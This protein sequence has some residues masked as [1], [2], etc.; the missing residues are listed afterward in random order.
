MKLFP[1]HF[2]GRDFRSSLRTWERFLKLLLPILTDFHAEQN[3]MVALGGGNGLDSCLEAVY[4]S[5]TTSGFGHK[6]LNDGGSLAECITAHQLSC[7]SYLHVHS[8]LSEIKGRTWEA[9]SLSPYTSPLCQ[10]LDLP[11]P[12]LPTQQDFLIG[13]SKTFRPSH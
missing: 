3:C 4:L 2:W 11:Q 10:G 7:S 1:T 6:A 8:S 12:L 5:T 13:I 9:N